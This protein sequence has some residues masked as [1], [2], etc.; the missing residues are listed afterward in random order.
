M[1]GE[2]IVFSAILGTK[3]FWNLEAILVLKFFLLTY[4]C[5]SRMYFD[6]LQKVRSVVTHFLHF[7][8]IFAVIINEHIFKTHG[9]INSFPILFME[10]IYL[11]LL[12][13][14]LLICFVFY[15]REIMQNCEADVR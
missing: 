12:C 7:M 11:A 10:Y 15:I 6:H 1:I 8:L 3:S 13:L 9:L 2:K 5:C 4:Y 14:V